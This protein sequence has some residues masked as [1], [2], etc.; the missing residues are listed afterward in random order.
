ME[1]CV[2]IILCIFRIV[3]LMWAAVKRGRSNQSMIFE[4]KL[5]SLVRNKVFIGQIDR[6]IQKQLLRNMCIVDIHV[7]PFLHLQ[8]S[9]NSNVIHQQ[10]NH[11][12]GT[13]ISHRIFVFQMLCL[14]HFLWMSMEISVEIDRM[15][16][17]LNQLSYLNWILCACGV[18]IRRLKIKS[19][20]W[21]SFSYVWVNLNCFGKCNV[22]VYLAIYEKISR[23]CH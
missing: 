8:I 7:M 9:C 5:V 21:R 3:V 23:I 17:S 6:I 1:S 4:H 20:D 15:Y 2:E 19:S 12:L 16:S 14:A 13:L 22:F 11:H 18:T 10:E